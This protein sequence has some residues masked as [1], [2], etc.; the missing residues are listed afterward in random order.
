MSNHDAEFILR[1][2]RQVPDKNSIQLEDMHIFSLVLLHYFIE[3]NARLDE[4]ARQTLQAFF[5]AVR[6][7]ILLTKE[8]ILHN[9]IILTEE[10]SRSLLHLNYA[11]YQNII[12][13]DEVK[14][15]YYEVYLPTLKVFSYALLDKQN[16]LMLAHGILGVILSKYLADKWDILYEDDN[17]LQLAASL[18]RLNNFLQEFCAKNLFHIL[19]NLKILEDGYH[20]DDENEFAINIDPVKYPLEFILWNRAYAAHLV[21]RPHSHKG[22]NIYYGHGHSMDDELHLVEKHIFNLDKQNCA[23]YRSSN[24]RGNDITEDKGWMSYLRANHMPLDEK[25][26]AL[27]FQFQNLQLNNNNTNNKPDVEPEGLENEAKLKLE[28]K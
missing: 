23:G 24:H 21:P 12:T 15:Q 13:L 18:D 8:N 20:I 27:T 10:H 6:E 1:M 11:I 3:S 14:R 28:K 7:Y 19:V 4:T 22:Y 26:K 16:I 2:E 5:A 17:P 25:T 9:S